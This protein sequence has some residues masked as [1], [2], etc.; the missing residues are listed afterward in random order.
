MEGFSRTI[1][2]GVGDRLAKTSL[3]IES[4]EYLKFY[5]GVWRYFVVV[6]HVNSNTKFARIRTTVIE[7]AFVS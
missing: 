4:H 1:F 3:H 5:C 7:D 2:S 6:T